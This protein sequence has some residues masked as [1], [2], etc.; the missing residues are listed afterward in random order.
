MEGY[1]VHRATA[2]ALGRQVLV[3][4]VA[5]RCDR[6]LALCTWLCGKYNLSAGDLASLP[7]AVGRFDLQHPDFS[8][9]CRILGVYQRRFAA[10]AA[11]ES[12]PAAVEE[13]AGVR[14]V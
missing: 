7:E 9:L 3:L 8:R 4:G 10:R 2:A 13:S 5:E 6:L 12:K 1:L 11:R 14:S